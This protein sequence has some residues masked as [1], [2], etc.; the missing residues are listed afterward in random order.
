MYTEEVISSDIVGGKPFVRK[1]VE[2]YNET[3]RQITD[4]K[5]EPTTERDRGFLHTST[6][7]T[8]QKLIYNFNAK[9]EPTLISVIKTLPKYF[10]EKSVKSFK[11]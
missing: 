5:F 2:K 9:H 8:A 10:A 11:K 4:M 3:A 6:E 7:Y 1:L